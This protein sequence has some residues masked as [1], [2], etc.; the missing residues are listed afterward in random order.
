MCCVCLWFWFGCLVLMSALCMG[1]G[2]VFHFVVT[3]VLFR[4]CLFVVFFSLL[5]LSLLSV[6]GDCGL[7]CFQIRS[8]A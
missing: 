7:G 2:A 6:F 3:R 8:E 1:E 4:V 5:L